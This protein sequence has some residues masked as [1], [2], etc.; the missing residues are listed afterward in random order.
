MSQLGNDLRA[1]FV[2]ALEEITTLM[3]T[4][5]EQLGP[6]PQDHALAQTGLRDGG[7][8]VLDYVDH[9][10]A[11]VA[12]EHLL[13]MVD[14]PPLVVSEECLEVLARIAKTLGVPFTR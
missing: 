5:Y 13:Y 8:I 10:E 7:E 6:V 9:N 2:E 3:S 11:G 14:E 12:F 1:D 4:A